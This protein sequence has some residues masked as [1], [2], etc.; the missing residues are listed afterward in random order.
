MLFV[1]VITF[2]F[3]FFFFFNINLLLL[4]LM[5]CASTVIFINLLQY[6][7]RLC[8]SLVPSG[9]CVIFVTEQQN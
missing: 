2:F 9:Y 4:L 1:I 5:Y 6:R 3:F 7:M 8:L